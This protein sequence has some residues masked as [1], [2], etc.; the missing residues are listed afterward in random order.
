MAD[1][2]G[3]VIESKS[4]GPFSVLGFSRDIKRAF[5]VRF[6]NTGYET[7][8]TQREVETG[9]IDD[10]K[11]RTIIG[12]GYLDGEPTRIDGDRRKNYSRWVSM[13]RRCY[14][15]KSSNYARYGQR[16]IKVCDRWHSF[17]NYVD[18]I[19]NLRGVD[20][21]ERD[22]IDR[23]DNDGDYSPANC[24]WATPQEQALNRS[25]SIEFYAYPPGDGDKLYSENQKAFAKKHGLT[26]SKISECLHGKYDQHKGWRFEFA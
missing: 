4:C 8:A 7:V 25:T 15:K 9:N 13:I 20:D 18:D 21:P 14:E 12:V 26:G 6:V 1:L 22:S 2:V 23:I 3:E 11:K 5:V 24:R 17:K 16:G 10:P 19:N